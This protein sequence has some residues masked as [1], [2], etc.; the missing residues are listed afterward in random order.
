M[1]GLPHVIAKW[2]MTLDG[3]SATASGDS[4]WIS[5]AGSRAR[6]HQLRGLMDA[7]AVGIG[8]VLADDPQLTARPPGPRTPARVV[9][10]SK[11]R[12]PVSSRLA[13]TAREVPVLVAVSREAPEERLAM[14]RDRGCEILVCPG[15][16]PV[17]IVP[18]LEELG[19]RGM[20]NI[21]VEGGGRVLGAFLDAGQVDEVDVYVAPILEGG[22]HARTPSR[23]AGRALMSEAARLE[24]VRHELIE[25]DVRIR[26]VLPQPWRSRLAALRQEAS[27][28]A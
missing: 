3:K 20:T 27:T 11:A 22:D 19:R 28:S 10:D 13:G 23:G 24:R 9:L 4:R 6:V 17:P 25:D 26:G 15:A 2:A 14:L 21:L 5:S 8:T 18:L 16:S 7:V 1:T 12:L